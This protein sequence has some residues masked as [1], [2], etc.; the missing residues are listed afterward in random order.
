MSSVNL[1]PNYDPFAR[2]Y[3]E[4]WGPHSCQTKLPQ[5]EKLLIQHHLPK[6]AHILDLCC[7]TGQ[8]VQQL[9]L[10]GYQVTG[11]DS[12]EGMLY[13]ARKNAPTAEF[14][15]GDARFFELPTTYHAVVST[16]IGL[17]HIMS[18]EELK[19]VFKK[20][21]DAL[22]NNGLFVFDLIFKGKFKSYGSDTFLTD[23]EVKDDY[24][25]ACRESYDPKEKINPNIMTIFELIEEQWQR[26][27][28]TWIYKAYTEDEVKSTLDNV[29]FTGVTL[30]DREGN[31]AKPEGNSYGIFVGRKQIDR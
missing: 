8:A 13:Y 24:A 7:G 28:I 11:L 21:Y 22:Q 19:A 3:N 2:M 12:S 20:V 17:N 26:S 14:I 6:G 30:Y 5:V 10:K 23:G 31:L 1:Y 25:W 29:G 15:L 27:D 18:I 9:V 16:N 4:S